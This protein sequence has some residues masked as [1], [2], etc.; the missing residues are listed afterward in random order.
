VILAAVTTSDQ[1]Y[2]NVGNGEVFMGITVQDHV[3]ARHQNPRQVVVAPHLSSRKNFG[4]HNNDLPNL[5][6]ALN[7]RVFNVKGPNGL[8][9]T[10]QPHRGAWKRLTDVGHRIADRVSKQSLE[11]LTRAEF[12]AQCPASKRPLYARA[13]D[14]YEVR[15]WSRKDAV[16]KAFVKFEKLDFTKKQDPAPRVIQP[17]SPVYNYALG[18]FTRR[19][20]HSIYEA[21]AE[22]WMGRGTVEKVVMKG[23]TVTQV[24][25]EIRLKWDKLK[26][27]VAVGLDASRFDQ[28]VSADALRWEHGVYKRIFG[29]DGELCALLAT[30]LRNKGR[31]FTDGKKV[32]Y[33]VEGTRASGDMNTSLGNCLI[34]CTLIREYVREL[35]IV[36]QFVNNGDDCVLF[37]EES[38]VHRLDGLYD[39]MLRYGF[40]MEIEDKVTEFEHI[41]FCQSQPVWS[42]SEWVMV[43]QP[44]T[45]FGKDALAL[46]CGTELAYRQWAYQVG[47]GG[48]ALYGDMPIYC[49]Y[50]EQFR[51]NGVKSNIDHSNILLNSGFMRM[52][53][54]PRIRAGESVEVTDSCRV[55]FYKAFGYP[56]SLQ[57]LV[58]EHLAELVV[59][60][61]KR[62]QHNTSVAVGL[63]TL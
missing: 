30:Q 46:G 33:S 31:I 37:V 17:R 11:K 19:I 52:S 38:D 27:P 9:P 61:I 40:E 16:I 60:G 32:T 63:P 54:V 26:C 35:G 4:A 6:R 7:E 12:L 15:G 39:W 8:M 42:G 45:A 41:V 25:A 58:E 10:P 62:S 36:A 49:K 13:A 24:A 51:R 34:M 3:G 29:Y 47:I 57:R 18:R 5:L 14:D 43:R 53:K 28:H 56:P 23:L 59:S 44:S 22:E 50:Y 20:E 1:Q 2:H 48:H 55:S 21:L